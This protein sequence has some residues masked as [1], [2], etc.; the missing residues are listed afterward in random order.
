MR[1]AHNLLVRGCHDKRVSELKW[2]SWED[3]INIYLRE[4][5]CEVLE[6]IQLSQDRI[7]WWAFVGTVMNIRTPL[8]KK[9]SNYH[10]SRDTPYHG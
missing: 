1:S 2:R 8:I 5:G 9:I 3:N 10:L 4:I 6:R 7:Q